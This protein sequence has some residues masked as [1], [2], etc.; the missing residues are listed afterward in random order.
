MQENR[1][2]F[3][4]I[5]QELISKIIVIAILIAI[6]L[7]A[8]KFNIESTVIFNIVYMISSGID[9]VCCSFAM[10]SKRKLV[11]KIYIADTVLLTSIVIQ[12]MSAIDSRYNNFIVLKGPN[13]LSYYLLI[14]SIFITFLEYGCQGKHI[15]KRIQIVSYVAA[16]IF[17]V[18]LI[19]MD[20]ADIAA[21][22]SLIFILVLNIKKKRCYFDYKIIN[23]GRLNNFLYYSVSNLILCILISSILI[24]DKSRDILSLICNYLLFFNI[25]DLSMKLCFILLNEQYNNMIYRIG[26]ADSRIY[27]MNKK[28][29][30]VKRH[31]KY[32]KDIIEKEERIMDSFIVNMPMSILTINRE[33]FRIT[34]VNK[35]MLMALGESD[36]KNI[37]NKKL[38]TI[39][40]I[41]DC[42]DYIDL[43][44]ANGELNYNGKHL[45]I[46]IGV[47][48]IDEANENITLIIRDVTEKVMSDKLK[49]DMKEKEFNEKIKRDFLSNI[50][51]DLKT[52]INVIYSAVQVMNI[53]NNEDGICNVKKYN[54]IARSNCLS[55][56]K[57]ADNLIN[58]GKM[59]KD[60]TEMN[61][62]KCD[63]CKIIGNIVYSLED[64]ARRRNI[65]IQF[66]SYKKEVYLE[67]DIEFMERIITNLIS[68]SIKFIEGSG[69]INILVEDNGDKEQI[70]IEDNGIGMSEETLQTV[71]ERYYMGENN[72]SNKDKGTGLGLFLAKRMIDAQGGT[73]EAKSKENVGTKMI[74]NFDKVNKNE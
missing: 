17:N 25:I 64:Y 22:I 70:V 66:N 57:Y 16:Y 61:K 2:S 24:I 52:P 73:I 48:A 58:E 8:Y 6:S 42:E 54:E 36:V 4:S 60:I 30:N 21:I 55:L 20:F 41:D 59:S 31:V 56:I 19:L 51:H 62:E 53:Y 5:K 71:F 23:N 45:Y 32:S 18:A 46:N 11:E 33:T 7:F 43:E 63:I 67:I 9:L 26:E 10:E 37:V 12:F 28:V 72:K 13:M 34:F 29:D 65:T 35:S 44:D 49:E 3:I 38:T 47:F 14:I 68:N 74:I 39:I 1:R 15:S 69:I 40:S 27:K 50:S